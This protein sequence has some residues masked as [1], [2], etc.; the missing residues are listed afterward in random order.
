MAIPNFLQEANKFEIEMYKPPQNIKD[1]R[2]THVPFTGSLQRHPYDSAK[3]LLIVDPYSNNTFYY[4]FAAADISFAEE[5]P[6]I[7]NLDDETIT[8]ARIWVKKKSVAVRCT[9]FLV[10]DIFTIA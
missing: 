9:P 10:E 4:E 6:S 8:M 1:L 7:V 5:L 3:I 2:R